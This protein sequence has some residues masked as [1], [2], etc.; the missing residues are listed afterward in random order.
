MTAERKLI[1]DEEA[2]V[3]ILIEAE[4]TM[5]RLYA[6]YDSLMSAYP[7]QW[8]AVGRDGLVARH[9]TLE[10]LIASFEAAGYNSNQVVVK[11][12]NPEPEWML[13]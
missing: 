6:D 12:L 11:H 13:L 10:G 4:A 8:V 7:D 5:Q 9:V 3:A 1:E 2:K